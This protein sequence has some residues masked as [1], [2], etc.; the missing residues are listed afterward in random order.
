MTFIDTTS[1]ARLNLQYI[2]KFDYDRRTKDHYAVDSDGIRHDIDQYDANLIP[3]LNT[4]NH[5]VPAILPLTLL[6]VWVSRSNPDD[7]VIDRYPI[8]AWIV[9]P[10]GGYPRPIAPGCMNDTDWDSQARYFI[11]LPSGKFQ[12]VGYEAYLLNTLD[13]CIND[14]RER[15]L[16]DRA[17]Q[18]RKVAAGELS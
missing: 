6:D 5:I 12:Q 13:E 2:K 4:P 17:E 14:A 18:E 1:G 10:D 7:V 11:E 15:C 8:V 16:K 9:T 3:N